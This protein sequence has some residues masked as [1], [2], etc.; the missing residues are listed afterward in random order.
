MEWQDRGIVLSAR[1]HGETAAVVT[2]LTPE[3]GR[4]LGLVHGGGSRRA[5]GV[6]QPGNEVAVRWR[7][8]LEEHLGSF[9]CDLV[10]S[11]AA[12]V[13]DDPLRLAGL[14]AACAT[15]EFATPERAPVPA[16]YE[17][18][19]ALLAAMPGEDWAEHY[20]RWELTLLAE[21]GFGLDME[22]CAAT[23]VTEGL[24][25]VSPRTGRA[26]SAEGAG[27]WREK[28]LPLPAFLLDAGRRASAAEVSEAL[29]LTG[30]FLEHHAAA[31]TAKPVPAART[32]LVDALHRKTTISGPPT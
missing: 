4:H 26:V 17:T 15:V 7:A 18:F 12:A 3:H 9:A 21:L 19:A 2:V 10:R 13:M 32:R 20:A 16:V 14:S 27:P 5:A 28:L 31:L 6:L 29:R 30:H 22:A 25:Y 23:G 24:A 8:R 1:L 11:H